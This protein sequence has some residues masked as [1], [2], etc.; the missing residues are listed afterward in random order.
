VIIPTLI[1]TIRLRNGVAPLWYLHLRRL[2]ESCRTLGVPFPL[3]MDVPAGGP[4]RVVKLEVGPGGM[5]VT[6]RPLE[7]STSVRLATVRTVHPGYSHKTTA[8]EA[9]AR[10][11]VEAI[12]KGADDALLLTAAGMVAECGIWSLFWW[13][14]AR[15]AGPPL[16]IGVLR[17]VARMRIEELRGRVVEQTVTRQQLE[18]RS[19]FVANAVRGVVPVVELDGRAVP[20]S[21]LLPPLAA[22]FWA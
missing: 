13:E 11:R 4:D 18:D 20:E 1:E 16:G 8:R 17:G 15:V 22:Q 21:A 19:L 14:G 5:V 10:A 6:E 2:S 9:F 7:L 12:A 3:K